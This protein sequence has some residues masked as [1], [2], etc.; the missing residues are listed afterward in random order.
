M[1]RRITLIAAL[2]ALMALPARAETLTIYT[3]DSFVSEWGPGP[4]IEKAFEARCAC[5]IEWTAVDDAALLLSRLRLEGA[6]TRADVVLGLDTNL[7]SEAK[8]EGLVQEHGISLAGLEMP[9][10]WIDTVSYE[11][12]N[13]M[14]PPQAFTPHRARTPVGTT[15]TVD[16]AEPVNA[17]VTLTATQ[18]LAALAA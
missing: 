6:M 17:T 15:V 12:T 3:Y 9:F 7:M 2:F 16:F 1:L 5:E 11:V 13:D 10:D 8:N 4:A 14:P 18:G